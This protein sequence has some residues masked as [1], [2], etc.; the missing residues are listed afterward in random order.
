M[1]LLSVFEFGGCR[2]NA[3]GLHVL[4]E[5][6]VGL[7][8]LVLVVRRAFVLVVAVHGLSETGWTVHV[9]EELLRLQLLASTVLLIGLGPFAAIAS[10]QCNFYVLGA[11]PRIGEA[12]V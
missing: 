6:A 12:T 4:V 8:R 9:S 2:F 10:L 1:R 7:L 11:Q 5:V 3:A